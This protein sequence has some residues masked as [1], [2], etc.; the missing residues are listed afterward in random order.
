MVGRSF[1]HSKPIGGIAGVI[2][3]LTHEIAHGV[4]G[5]AL[6]TIAAVCQPQRS[7]YAPTNLAFSADAFHSFR[8]DQACPGAD[9]CADALRSKRVCVTLFHLNLDSE[10][11]SQICKA[12]LLALTS[13][14]DI[15]MCYT[16]C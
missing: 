9:T 10:K 11:C 14:W 12:V 8:M 7:R 2:S 3:W 15:R 1:F 4:P 5:S 6:D 16:G 13:Q